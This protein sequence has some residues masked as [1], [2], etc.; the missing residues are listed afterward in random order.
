MRQ[1]GC[2]VTEVE[3]KLD[4]SPDAGAVLEASELLAGEPERQQLHATYFDTPDQ[5]LRNAGFSLRIR[6]SGTTRIQTIKADGAASAGLFLRSEWEMEVE[7]DTPVLDHTTPV[8]AKLGARGEEIVPSFEVTVERRIWNVEEDGAQIEVVLDQGQI[9]SGGREEA[10]CE[11]EL[12]L[13]SGKPPALF[14]LA[15]KLDAIAPMHI[16]VLSKAARG[17][18]LAKKPKLAFKAEPVTLDPE[19]D[20]A[21]AFQRIAQACLRQFRLNEAAVLESRAPE[22][23]H[24][25]RVAL[26][27]LRSAF[28]VFSPLFEA[29]DQAALL[30]SE[31]RE[32]AAILGEARNLDVLIARAGDGALRDRLQS[33]REEAYA[34]VEVALASPRA[35][36]LMLDLM[37]WLAVGAWLAESERHSEITESSRSFAQTALDRYRRKVKK[38]GRRLTKTDDEARHDLRKDAKKLRY[39]AEFFATLFD[40][41]KS[42][43]RYKRFIAALEDMQDQLGVL[44]DLATAPDEIRKL[45]L[46]DDPEA[47]ALLGSEAKAPLIA[48]AAEAHEAL[49]DA[50][51][52]WR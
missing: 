39:A 36:S 7:S 31:L 15:R 33:A 19:M 48:A 45:G 25:A 13:K 52:F 12:E 30:R 41:K 35:R 5:A 27:R 37:E 18:R 1:Q 2:T 26:R 40:D 9:R 29:D 34:N 50:K 51:R 3:L 4:V 20:A 14:S 47:Q 8:L 17:Y 32:I 42:R 10:V 11:V 49:V 22:A 6:T 46:E 16:G 28:S 23:L 43:R 24:Q 38:G 44:N 21:T